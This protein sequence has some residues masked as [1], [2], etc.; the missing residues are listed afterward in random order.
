MGA[1]LSH[2]PRY[3]HREDGFLRD[4][5]ARFGGRRGGCNSDL[6]TS[7]HSTELPEDESMALDAPHHL[8]QS[9]A[10]L[11]C[12]VHNKSPISSKEQS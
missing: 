5:D 12:I 1:I 9:P 3:P 8:R 2:I 4:V 7:V 11:S 6:H 10:H